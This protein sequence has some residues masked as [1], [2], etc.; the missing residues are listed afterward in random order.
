MRRV[1]MVLS[2]AA[3]AILA[4]SAVQANYWSTAPNGTDYFIFAN[5]DNGDYF[6]DP[7]FNSPTATSQGALWLKTGSGAPAYLTQEREREFDLATQHVVILE[8]NRHSAS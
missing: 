1:I 2:V 7:P 6:Y 8:H 5:T 4:A 3:I